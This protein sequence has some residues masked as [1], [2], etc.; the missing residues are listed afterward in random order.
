MMSKQIAGLAL[1]AGAAAFSIGASA[2]TSVTVS[3]MIDLD[4]NSQTSAATGQRTTSLQNGGFQTSFFQIGGSEDLGG[5]LKADFRLGSFFQA[6]NGTDGRFPGDT[7]FSR[8]ANIGLSGNFGR[9]TLGRQISPLYLSTLLFNPFDDS[10]A[11]SPIIQHTYNAF[12][13][14]N[15]VNADSGYSNAVSYSTPNFQGLSATVLYTVAGQ[16]GIANSYSVN[17]LYFHGPFA[18]TAAY[19]NTTADPTNSFVGAYQVG[20]TQ[21]VAQVGMSYDFAPAKIYFQYE[22]SDTPLAVTGGPA[23]SATSGLNTFQV[24]TKINAGG[25]NILA[26]YA[27]TGGWVDHK[28]FSAGYDYDL[29]KR[30]DVYA[31]YMNDQ[32]A[33]YVDTVNSFSVGLRH[34]F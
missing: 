25:G 1:A 14:G 27:K 17:L 31:M 33:A 24:G 9:V 16:I 5:G 7:L 11:F 12:G 28:T 15:V 29:S 26:S 23:T 8:D 32:A 10:F 4:L 2:Q 30:T 3:G 20:S 19:E 13:A 6:N 21:K 18:A 34:R 22:H